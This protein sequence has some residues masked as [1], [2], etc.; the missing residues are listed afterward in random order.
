MYNR[1]INSLIRHLRQATSELYDQP[2]KFA[3]AMSVVRKVGE[4]IREQKP[5]FNIEQFE[6]TVRGF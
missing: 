4:A 6:K 3:V 1:E 5:N 2:T